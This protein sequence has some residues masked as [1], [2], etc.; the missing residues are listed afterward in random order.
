MEAKTFTQQIALWQD[1]VYSVEQQLSEQQR[2]INDSVFHLYGMEETDEQV[3]EESLSVK[4]GGRISTDDGDSPQTEDG[5]K[6]IASVD[7]SELVADL[8]SY[9]VGCVFGRWDARI[10]LAPSL[11]PK[12]ADPFAPL[13]VC[14]PGTLV[15]PDS[16]SAGRDGIASE[17]WMRERP[18]AITPPPDGS[19]ENPTIPDSEYPL[20]VD[21]DGILVG[22]PDHPDDIVRRV[23]DVLDLLWG[24]RADEIEH[25]AC[26]LLG[27]KDLRAYFRNPRKFWD[28]H[29]KRYSKSRRKAPIYWLLQSPKKNFGL[30]IYYHRLDPDIL[31]KALTKYVEPKIRLEESRLDEYEA[32]RRDAGTGGSEAKKAEKAVQDQETLLTDLCEFR[33]RLQRAA[34][35]YLRPDLNDGVVLNIAPLHELVPWKEAKSKW[36]ELLAGKYEWSSIGKQLREKGL[37]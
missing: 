25:E 27:I 29:V 16:L 22:D 8:L 11:A 10:A 4:N 24:G 33:D 31:F 7:A 1:R 9:A 28:F 26:E 21:W 6:A 37:V 23:R 36:D 19:V 14:S 20:A 12:L 32:Q 17:E 13:P 30:W 2:E 34:G 18:D 35:L 15:G 5:E 3:I